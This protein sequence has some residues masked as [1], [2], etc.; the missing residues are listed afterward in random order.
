MKPYIERRKR[1]AMRL[2]RSFWGIDSESDHMVVVGSIGRKTTPGPA[3]DID[4]LFQLPQETRRRVSGFMG[5]SQ[6]ALLQIIRNELRKTYPETKIRGDGQVVVV[7]FSDTMKFEVVP[8]FIQNDGSFLYP[9]SNVGGQWKCCNPKAEQI[10]FDE[11]NEKLDGKL[12]HLCRM[13][14]VWRKRF[15]IDLPGIF[16]DA[17]SYHFLN[18]WQYRDENYEYYDWMF[19]DYMGYLSSI[20]PNRKIWFVPGSNAKVCRPFNI[21]KRA[22]EAHSISSDACEFSLKGD[23]RRA[24][25]RW[26][27]IFGGRFSGK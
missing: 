11:L 19:R 23:H 22:S 12:R 26:Q 16:I 21:V 14:R 17:T 18:D 10:A 7:G 13:T 6:S 25:L 9:D 4:V 24:F 3:K 2:N 15:S 20:D 1:L 5:N 27:Q 8:A